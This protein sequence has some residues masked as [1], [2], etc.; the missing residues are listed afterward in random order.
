MA[1]PHKMQCC[2]KYISKQAIQDI[3]DDGKP[4]PF[5]MATTIEYKLDQNLREKVRMVRVKCPHKY[6]GCHWSGEIRHLKKH[7]HGEEDRSCKFALIACPSACGVHLQRFSVEKH[8]QICPIFNKQLKC[9]HCGEMYSQ[10]SRH[11]ETC[12]M[13]PVHCP[14]K[15]GA[16]VTRVDIISHLKECPKLQ[17][18][19]HQKHENDDDEQIDT[20]ESPK[21]SI[22]DDLGKTFQEREQTS[23][24]EL[25]DRGAQLLEIAKK[26][27]Q[28]R[29][30]LPDVRIKLMYA[31]FELIMHQIEAFKGQ[32]GKDKTESE[33][34]EKGSELKNKEV[35]LEDEMAQL[36]YELLETHNLITKLRSQ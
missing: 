28:A 17:I 34:E 15:C 20:G 29:S 13:L 3:L 35:Q 23:N 25:S 14:Y 21:V 30:Q 8:L 7:L 12:T 32:S 1:D 16:K 31:N 2:G 9:Q 26:L 22:P 33:F 36:R 11:W 4:C 10:T 5:C 27:L 6:E 18:D 19:S 24:E